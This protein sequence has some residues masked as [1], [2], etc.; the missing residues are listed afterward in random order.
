MGS[1]TVYFLVSDKEYIEIMQLNVL[2]S[3]F[4]CLELNC[5]DLLI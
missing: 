3:C 1:L 2:L 5:C 4:K